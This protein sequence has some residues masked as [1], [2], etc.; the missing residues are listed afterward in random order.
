MK[1]L[2][3]LALGLLTANAFA[4]GPQFNN[5]TKSD[6]ENISKE[7]SANFSHT[8]VSAPETDGLW[9]V[10]VG[11][12]AGKTA[13]PDL[14]DVVDASSGNGSDAASLYHAGAMARVHIPGEIFAEVNLLPEQTLSDISVKNTSYEI[15]WNAGGFF[16]LPI[17]VAIA[18]NMANSAFSIKQTSP[19]TSTTTIDSSTRIYWIGLSKTLFI[20]TPYVKFGSVSSDTDLAATGNILG[21]NATEKD[22]V[23]NSGGYLAFGGNVTLGFLKLGAEFSKIMGVSRTSGKISF[24]F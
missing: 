18:A 11:V 3:S 24:D 13:S 4:G 23:T 7:F 16:N 17:D 19:V 5:L 22:S 1:K 14:K 9:G 21:Y 20:F 15:G 12:V 2:L 6:V 8:G 10:E